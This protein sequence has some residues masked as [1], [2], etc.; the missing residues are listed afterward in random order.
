MYIYIY[1]YIYKSLE[2]NIKI[3]QKYFKKDPRK[4]LKF[5][6]IRKSKKYKYV[7]Q[8]YMNLSEKEKKIWQISKFSLRIQK[9]AKR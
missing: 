5:F 8:Q 6:L 7:Y 1:I 2:N 3:S 4:I 9:S